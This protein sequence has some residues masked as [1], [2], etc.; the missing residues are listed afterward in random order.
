MWRPSPRRDRTS[1]SSSA[2]ADEVEEPDV[3]LS[4]LRVSQV[5]GQAPLVRRQGRVGSRR[6]GSPKVP[7]SF[8]ARSNQVS[9]VLVP[10]DPL[11]KPRQHAVRRN[12]VRGPRDVIGWL[13]W[14]R[15]GRSPAA[16][17]RGGKL[18][19][20]LE[21]PSKYRTAGPR[22]HHHSRTAGG[23]TGHRP[24]CN[25][26]GQDN[27]LRSSEP[28]AGDVDP[29]LLWTWYRCGQI[30]VVATIRKELWPDAAI[31]ALCR[32]SRAAQASSPARAGRPNRSPPC[33]RTIVPFVTPAARQDGSSRV[34]V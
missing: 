16:R 23:R 22:A 7:C 13:R 1:A 18:S 24:R 26:V 15:S 10:A 6:A 28:R 21:G 14:P 11:G 30:Q 32:A 34:V 25:W 20:E 33:E 29:L 5:H 9:E 31:L 3:A 17:P 19:G 27:A 8:P 12:R 2:A 4:H